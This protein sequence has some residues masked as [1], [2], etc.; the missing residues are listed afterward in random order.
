MI[1]ANASAPTNNLVPGWH[2]I[3]WAKRYK[4]VKRL[5]ARIVKAVQENRWNKVKVLQHLL[6]CSFSGKV[7]AIRRV[8]ENKGKRTS[9]VDQVTWDTPESKY[10]AIRLLKKR[11][12]K[13]YPLR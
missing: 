4:I 13:S 6:T 10:N 8:T 12:Y 3:E 9:G 5:Q 2:S 11:G 1:A 7:L